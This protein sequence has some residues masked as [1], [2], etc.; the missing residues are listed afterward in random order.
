MAASSSLRDYQLALAERLQTAAAGTRVASKLGLQVG[1]ENWLV[2]LTEAGEVIP[3][4]PIFPVP[5]AHSWFRGVVNVRGN[6]YSVT[7]LPAFLAAK[8]VILSAHARLLLV[9]DRFRAGAALL[10]ERSLG[11]RNMEQL[12]AKTGAARA[13]WARAEYADADNKLWKELDVP[14]LMQ[15]Q[16]FLEVSL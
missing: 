1:E 6:L 10:V 3:V 5:L 16:A 12:S 9:A 15:D 8:P 7:D 14:A 13:R 11:L 2:D 4:P